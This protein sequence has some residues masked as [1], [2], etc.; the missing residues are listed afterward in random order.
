[1]Q[2][3]HIEWMEL[4]LHNTT[5]GYRTAFDRVWEV[6]QSESLVSL[7]RQ[8]IMHSGRVV[9]YLDNNSTIIHVFSVLFYF[10]FLLQMLTF[11]FILRQIIMISMP[12][13]KIKYIT[14][15]FAHLFF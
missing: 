8:F 2:S 15:A 1:M 4:V 12:I 13:T 3:L 5:L 11:I 10:D 6:I 7:S 9:L 14:N